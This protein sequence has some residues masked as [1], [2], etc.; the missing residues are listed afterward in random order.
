MT[1]GLYTLLELTHSRS[2]YAYYN[3]YIYTSI[4]VIVHHRKTD[5]IT[6][7]CHNNVCV[8][9]CVMIDGRE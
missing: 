8:I 1:G 6:Y 4:R 9:I 2:V 3:L 5:D 7:V